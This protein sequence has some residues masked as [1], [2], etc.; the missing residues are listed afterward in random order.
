[1]GRRAQGK[2]GSFGRAGGGGGGGCRVETSQAK[3]KKKSEK[4]RL[5][6][7]VMTS[8]A[9]FV[10]GAAALVLCPVSTPCSLANENSN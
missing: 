6:I 4:K 1:M 7:Q 10:R 2:D 3:K 8:L 9:G 5:L